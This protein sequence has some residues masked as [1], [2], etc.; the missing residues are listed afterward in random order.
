MKIL[1]IHT[2]IPSFIFLF[3][4]L[5]TKR[6]DKYLEQKKRTKKTHKKGKKNKKSKHKEVS[7]ES[8]EG[9]WP[10]VDFAFFCCFKFW[11]KFV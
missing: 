8:E 11:L 3:T 1:E 2:N 4:S 10:A 5:A 9:N 7:S 6:S